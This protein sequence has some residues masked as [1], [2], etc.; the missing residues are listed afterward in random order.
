MEQEVES[1]NSGIK[2]LT[3]V[4]LWADISYWEVIAQVE[5]DVI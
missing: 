5:F 3:L 4:N 2:W 1:F